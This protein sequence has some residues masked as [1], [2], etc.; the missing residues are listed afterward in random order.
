[1]I[2]VDNDQLIA[3]EQDHRILWRFIIYGHYHVVYHVLVCVLVSFFSL[4]VD[5]D[6]DDEPSGLY[7][8]KLRP[9]RLANGSAMPLDLKMA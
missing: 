7:S 1:M 3:C 4:I 2:A 9:S 8:L 6:N 5:D